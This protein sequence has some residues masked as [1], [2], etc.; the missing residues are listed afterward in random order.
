LLFPFVVRSGN[1]LHPTGLEGIPERH[2]LALI[3]LSLSFCIS[4]YAAYEAAAVTGKF[5]AVGILSPLKSG[6]RLVNEGQSSATANGYILLLRVAPT[7]M[8]RVRDG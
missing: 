3:L 2:N 5:P 7:A 1:I 6:I 4:K 8:E